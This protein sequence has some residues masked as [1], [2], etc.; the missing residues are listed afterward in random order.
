MYDVHA[1]Q[2]LVTPHT[3]TVIWHK[4]I[5]KMGMIAHYYQVNQEKEESVLNRIS[6]SSTEYYNVIAN[7]DLIQTHLDIDKS[8]QYLAEVFKD[9]KNDISNLNIGEVTFYG[10]E[11]NLSYEADG[12]LNFVYLESIILINKYLESLNITSQEAFIKRFNSTEFTRFG[13]MDYSDLYEYLFM[14][15]STLKEF[16][17]KC[18]KESSGVIVFIG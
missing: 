1:Q 14:H 5:S 9:I 10:E 6:A 12:L 7:K 16:Y 4:K 13:K 18:E 11:L 8:W 3:L 17:K 2:K 15:F